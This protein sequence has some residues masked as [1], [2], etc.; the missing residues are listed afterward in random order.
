MHRL[1]HGCAWSGLFP[2]LIFDINVKPF[3][4]PISILRQCAIIC[5]RLGG[6]LEAATDIKHISVHV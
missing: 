4:E 5:L 2:Y 3:L 6:S 1:L